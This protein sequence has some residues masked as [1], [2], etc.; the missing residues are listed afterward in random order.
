M[1]CDA[2]CYETAA[3]PFPL[4][5]LCQAKVLSPEAQLHHTVH[6]SNKPKFPLDTNRFTFILMTVDKGTTKNPYRHLFS[7]NATAHAPTT[8]PPQLP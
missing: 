1:V 4:S 3:K 6:Q 2:H 5:H 7:K 8:P